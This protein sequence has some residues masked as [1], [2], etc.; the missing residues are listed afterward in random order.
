MTRQTKRSISFGKF[1]YSQQGFF[2]ALCFLTITVCPF[3]IRSHHTIEISTY[4]LQGYPGG[5]PR[6]IDSVEINKLF[7]DDYFVF[8]STQNSRRCLI[9]QLGQLY[10][11]S[12]PL[13]DIIWYKY[14]HSVLLLLQYT[15]DLQWSHIQHPNSLRQD[16][17]PRDT[18]LE[19]D[20]VHDSIR[21]SVSLDPLLVLKQALSTR[22]YELIGDISIE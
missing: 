7:Y 13:S 17:F 16:V 22:K 6:T 18:I 9:V 12:D 19:A 14:I 3:L 2:V 5:Y 20:L 1:S 21:N 10:L 11:V 8:T 4:P 15:T